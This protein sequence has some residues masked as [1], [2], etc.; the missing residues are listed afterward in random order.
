MKSK[1]ERKEDSKEWRMWIDVI[2]IIL[3]N[4]FISIY[5]NIFRKNYIIKKEFLIKCNKNP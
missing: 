4:L 3:M 1:K 2:Y 5:I